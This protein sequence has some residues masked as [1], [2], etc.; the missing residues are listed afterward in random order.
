MTAINILLA[1]LG[2]GITVIVAVGMILLTPGGTESDVQRPLEQP[3]PRQ[4]P[5]VDRSPAVG[6]DPA[7]F[8]QPEGIAVHADAA[9]AAPQRAGPTP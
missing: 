7:V 1:C 6:P 5:R 2:G 8:S 9:P 4:G 3:Q